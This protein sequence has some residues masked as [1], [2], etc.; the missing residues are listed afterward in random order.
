MLRADRLPGSRLGPTETGLQGPMTVRGLE[1]SLELPAGWR[2]ARRQSQ[3]DPHARTE[4]EGDALIFEFASVKLTRV[5]HIERLGSEVTRAR[6]TALTSEPSEG[7]RSGQDDPMAFLVPQRG[8]VGR[9]DHA[10][11][12]DRQ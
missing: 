9:P 5:H 1:R 12:L 11:E 10:L 7:A 2:R 3:I 6:L 8:H 4:R